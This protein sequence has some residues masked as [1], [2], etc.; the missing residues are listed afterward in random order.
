MI[1]AFVAALTAL[2][3]SVALVAVAGCFGLNTVAF[4]GNA[5]RRPGISA[6]PSAFA[7][8]VHVRSRTAVADEG[9]AHAF[10]E[11][12]EAQIARPAEGFPG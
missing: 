2:E 7:E 1:S 8:I 5:C 4:V 12:Q 3:P 10:R 9:A 6:P 11:F